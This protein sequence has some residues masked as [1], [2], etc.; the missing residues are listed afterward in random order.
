MK[1]STSLLLLVALCAGADAYAP[2]KFY[3]KCLSSNSWWTDFIVLLNI[4]YAAQYTTPYEYSNPYHFPSLLSTIAAC[5]AEPMPKVANK[6]TKSSS[7]DLQKAATGAFAA[8]TIVAS[9]MTS[10]PVNAVDTNMYVAPIY[11]M[12]S[13]SL[14][15]SEKVT[16]EGMYGAYEVEV[17][18]QAFD[19]ARSTFKPAS[20]TKSKKG[21]VNIEGKFMVSIASEDVIIG[22]FMW[23]RIIFFLR[24][25]FVCSSQVN[26]RRCSPF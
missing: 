7:S 18:P 8:A 14:M 22:I 20:E 24:L 5:H 16:R 4:L 15:V 13:S 17:T 19:D 9:S 2:S 26:I 1:V 12:A 11:Q 3:A 21:K 10:M 6:T 25:H 23:T